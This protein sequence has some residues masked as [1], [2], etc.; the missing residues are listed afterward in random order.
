[1]DGNLISCI[2]EQAFRG[3]TFLEILTM[4][5]NNITTLWSGTF[6]HTPRLRALRISGNQLI[7][8]CQL[9]WL[10][11]WLASAP[12]LAP[13]IRCSSPSR[14]RDRILTDVAQSEFKCA[15]LVSSSAPRECTL[16]PVCPRGCLCGQGIVD[17]RDTGQQ[18]VPTHIP[19]DTI[20][21]RLEHNQ[22]VEVPSKA[23]AAFRLLKRIDLSNNEI[24]SIAD[25]AFHGLRSLNSI[26]L[27]G[28]KLTEISEHV[29]R[30]LTSL[31]L[32]LLNANKI[33][34]VHAN[35]FRDLVSLKVLSLYD[36]NIKTMSNGTFASMHIVHTIALVSR[37]TTTLRL[38]KKPIAKMHPDSFKCSTELRAQHAGRCAA[39]LPCPTPCTCDAT[40]VDCSG[41]ALSALPT[42]PAHT[43][44]LDLSY[45]ELHGAPLSVAAL[46]RLQHLDVSH[47]RLSLLPLALLNAAPNL[48]S[49]VLSNN[50][51]SCVSERIVQ[52]LPNLQRLELS[53][54]P[55]TC[56]CRS[57]WLSAWLADHASAAAPP[58]CRLP[59]DLRDLPV[60]SPAD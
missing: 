20:E 29:F 10:G 34:C 43:T 26:V 8:D 41:R 49:L 40:R 3:L 60:P 48:R 22:I 27:Y 21:L 2:D 1:M 44:H 5:D 24:A 35:A 16:S 51:I 42:L 58:T 14:L 12:H 37:Y 11:R 55:L 30:G 7:C 18:R 45:N 19:D 32:L 50:H 9:A 15:G 57:A 38:S 47:N 36:N 54:N 4:K 46:P 59:A 39:S 6:D 23:F 17:C 56:D 13:Y 25:D 31:Q 28:N 33:E 52:K 53:N